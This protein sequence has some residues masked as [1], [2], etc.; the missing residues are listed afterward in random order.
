MVCQLQLPNNQYLQDEKRN[1]KPNIIYHQLRKLPD[2][3]HT[4]NV[5]SLYIFLSYFNK[6]VSQ[7]V[8]L[9][10]GSKKAKA[11]IWQRYVLWGGGQ[12]RSDPVLVGG[13]WLGYTAELPREARCNVRG[14]RRC[15]A[16]QGFEQGW[17]LSHGAGASSLLF[18]LDAQQPT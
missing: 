9:N 15:D 2:A 6:Y 10:N 7:M 14:G 17:T 12:W 4:Q 13:V 11:R 3:W 5:L 1:Q 8:Y 16:W 18:I